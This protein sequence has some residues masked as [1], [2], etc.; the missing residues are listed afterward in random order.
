MA[1]AVGVGVVVRDQQGRV[2][3]G[4]R[5]KIGEQSSWS[6]PGG[7]LEAGESFETA[8]A[9][10]LAEETGLVARHVEVLALA[11]TLRFDGDTPGWTAAAVADT[12]GGQPQ[13]LAPHEFSE[14]GWFHDSALPEALFAP[15]RVVLD[16]AAG[17]A[18]TS[19]AANAAYWITSVAGPRHELDPQ[20]DEER[21][22][23]GER[24][25]VSAR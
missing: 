4:R 2:L 13:V 14:F 11:V 17:R 16:L 6:L 18:P 3:L 25:A 23:S 24:G 15:T 9:R 10:E 20:A 12:T 1:V 8:A 22:D 5:E 21:D 19:E 7:G